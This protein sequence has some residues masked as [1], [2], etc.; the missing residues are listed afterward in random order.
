M[1]RLFAL[2]G[3]TETA[4]ED[5][6]IAAV[7]TI[8]TSAG[9]VFASKPV[10]DVLELKADDASEAKVVQAITLMKHSHA[11]VIDLQKDNARM[12]KDIRDNAAEEVVRFARSKGKISR[13]QERWALEYAKSDID[14][15]RNF[16]NTAAVV[17]DQDLIEKDGPTFTSPG[18]DVD[19]D[20]VMSISAKAIE[21]QA[22]AEKNGRTMT[23]SEAVGA[24]VKKKR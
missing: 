11:M 19:M 16:V 8:K 12:E 10:L 24:V 22:A 6:A 3:L 21:F 15:F 2:L 5:D 7:T 20:V 13:E 1:K 4:T 14:G 18:S 17:L 9:Q 23:I